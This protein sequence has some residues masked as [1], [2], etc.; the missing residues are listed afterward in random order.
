PLVSLVIRPHNVE[1][2][3][4]RSRHALSVLTAWGIVM[5]HHLSSYIVA[6]LLASLMVLMVV[7]RFRPAGSSIRLSML[8]LY[9]FVVLSL[10]I[11]TF[12]YQIFFTHEQTFERVISQFLT[13]EDFPVTPG[14][15]GGGLGRTFS[16]IEI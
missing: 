6:S 5:T 7:P 16:S 15:A 3:A 12:T 10:Y 4:Q 8:V 11:V 1:R 2:T 9:F 13:P 14:A